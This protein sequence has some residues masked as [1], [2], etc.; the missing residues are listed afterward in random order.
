[1]E[2]YVFGLLGEQETREVEC[3]SKIYPEI[4][5][6]VQRIQST[7]TD[8]SG[9]WK[10]P[11]PVAMKA[12]ILEAI[13]N[14][15]QESSGSQTVAKEIPLNPQTVSVWNS[16]SFKMLAAACFIGIIALSALYISANTRLQTQNAALAEMKANNVTLNEQLAKLE[17]L[18]NQNKEDYAFLTDK[19][20][21]RIQLAGTQLDPNAQMEVFWNPIRKKVGV[22]NVSLPAVEKDK[23]Y[24]LWAIV[25][26]KPVDM[27]VITAKGDSITTMSF[28]LQNVQAFAVTKE[29]KGGSATPTLDQMYVLGSI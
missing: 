11:A 22:I 26:G 24:Q 18:L 25:D 15:P 3:M 27:G 19:A 12:R 6:E 23:D 21:Q 1:M 13:Q 28:G 20:T 16:R 5:Q 4:S 7:L 10:K 29:K 14:T 2:A 8:L 9:D 17:T